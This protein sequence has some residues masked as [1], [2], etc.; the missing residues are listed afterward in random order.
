MVLSRSKPREKT[1]RKIV[2]GI[3]STDK[4]R[5]RMPKGNSKETTAAP[6]EG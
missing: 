6:A 1:R 2:W 5:A 4:E 3:D